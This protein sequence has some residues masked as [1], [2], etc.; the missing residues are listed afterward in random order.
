MAFKKFR[1]LGKVQGALTEIGI[2]VAYAYDDLIFTEHNTFLLRFDDECD[3]NLFLHFNKDCTE[4]LGISKILNFKFE[5]IGYT[6]T[7]DKNYDIVPKQEK[8]EFDVV[9]I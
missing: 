9:F 7:K 5:S 6:L 8:E 1:D 4:T 2:E 3:N